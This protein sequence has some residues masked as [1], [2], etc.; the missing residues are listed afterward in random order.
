MGESTILRVVEEFRITMDSHDG[1][2]QLLAAEQEAQRIVGTARK[3]KQ[4]RL[5]QAKDEAEK[6]ITNYRQQ[7]D[8]QYKKKLADQ[9][10]DSSTVVMRLDQEAEQELAVIVQK[11]AR[12]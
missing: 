4:G 2:Q 6:E 1:I 3:A 12:N 7:R 8:T 11:V 10:G 9:S 5:R